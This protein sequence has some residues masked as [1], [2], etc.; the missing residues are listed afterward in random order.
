M[1]TSLI[2][3]VYNEEKYIAK[4]LDSVVDQTHQPDEVVICDNNS[5]DKT[6]SIIK[7]YRSKLPIRIVTEVKKGIQFA[8]DTAW[9]NASG[10]IIVRT[11]AD[12][13]LPS[14]WIE[15][16]LRR[17][18]QDSSL[19]AC[20]GGSRA[21]DGNII[22]SL[23]TPIATEINRSILH[24]VKGHLVLFGAN[25]A[26]KRAVLEKVNGYHS[27]QKTTQDDIMLSKKIHD[28]NCRY[29]YYPELWNYTSTRRFKNARETI[30]VML[31]IFTAKFYLEKSI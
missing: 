15:R 1:K 8:V 25:F 30:L 6:V 22:F 28:S 14:D 10:D 29:A 2:V 26:V 17:F 19:D 24:L 23:L 27:P 12:C 4:L 21:A 20:G 31:S 13:V 5:T 3:P 9:K 16:Y 7:R 11:D 18:D